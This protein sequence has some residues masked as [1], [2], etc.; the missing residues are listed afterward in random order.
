MLA[1]K[2]EIDP[3]KAKSTAV[4]SQEYCKGETRPADVT[5][6]LNQHFP[7]SSG[8]SNSSFEAG[9]DFLH[10]PL[11]AR[12]AKPPPALS[13]R[14]IADLGRRRKIYVFCICGCCHCITSS[15]RFGPTQKNCTEWFFADACRV[16]LKFQSRGS[17]VSMKFSHHCTGVLWYPSSWRMDGS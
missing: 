14:F 13:L 7:A 12:R 8:G 1:K 11:P 3:D 16:P 2:Q 4:A 17:T 5:A 9:M 6:A 10:S 15:A